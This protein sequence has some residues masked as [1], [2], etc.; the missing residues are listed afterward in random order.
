[1]AK[2]SAL[3]PSTWIIAHRSRGPRSTGSSSTH[4]TISKLLISLMKSDGRELI[5]HLA[6]H[7][8]TRGFIR[9]C[10]EDRTVEIKR[11][12]IRIVGHDPTDF[13]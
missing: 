7:G 6:T 2:Y 9:M 1:M 4:V 13:T 12:E 10:D 8:V 3:D 5:G 11:S